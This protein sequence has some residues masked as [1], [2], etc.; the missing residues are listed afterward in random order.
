MNGCFFSIIPN[1]LLVIQQ[2]PLSAIACLLVSTL[3][4]IYE[5]LDLWYPQYHAF[6]HAMVSKA[7]PFSESLLTSLFCLIFKCQIL[8]FAICNLPKASAVNHTNTNKPQFLLWIDIYVKK[9]TP[10]L[11]S[12]P[13][14][15]KKGRASFR[16]KNFKRIDVSHNLC[17]FVWYGGKFIDSI[18]FCFKFI[19]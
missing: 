8:F 1:Q 17:Q 2:N 14:S 5:R 10:N 18:W 11:E 15:S 13:S 6:P 3:P 4:R 16:S 9:F 7:W 12:W 19:L